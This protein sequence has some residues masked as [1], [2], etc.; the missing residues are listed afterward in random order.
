MQ[1]GK[2][3]VV[4]QI[5]YSE[6]ESTEEE[7]AEMLAAYAA[8]PEITTDEEWAALTPEEQEH[9]N[10]ISG[11]YAYYFLTSMLSDHGYFIV[12][13]YSEIEAA[14]LFIFEDPRAMEVPGVYI[15]EPQATLALQEELPL[16]AIFY[17]MDE[18]EVTW[19]SSDESVATV[20]AEGVVTP[21]AL[22][23]AVI[24]V[25]AMLDEQEVSDTIVI[26]VVKSV[27]KIASYVEEANE[28]FAAM[29]AEAELVLPD[30]EASKVWDSYCGWDEDYQAYYLNFTTEMSPSEY[31]SLLSDDYI[32]DTDED[33]DPIASNG[34]YV[35]GAYLDSFGDMVV[36]IY[37]DGETPVVEGDTVDFS[38]YDQTSGEFTSFSFN[39]D[40][41]TNPNKVNPD[42]NANNA[43]LRLYVGN[44]L[45]V[46]SDEEMTSIFFDANTCTHSD[47]NGTLNADVGTVTEVEGGFLWEGEATEV[48][49][50][51]ASGKQFHISSFTVSFGE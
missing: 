7:I 35:V 28:I 18:T 44:T 41:G 8:L 15:E 9:Y 49:F 25:S 6:R 16:E 30:P 47:A 46:S 26:H 40:V 45:T 37:L 48:T 31:I 23:D 10:L 36:Y 17:Q 42:Y 27:S 11:Q 43:E 1:K 50:S 20:S 34:I 33:G 19:S 4:A 38:E 51:V 24:T 2:I 32:I 5:V 12:C 13:D 21:V 22:G 14:G 29:G 39:T 3:V